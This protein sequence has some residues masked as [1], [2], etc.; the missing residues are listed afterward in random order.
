MSENKVELEYVVGVSKKKQHKLYIII[1][2]LLLLVVGLVY[3]FVLPKPTAT[4]EGVEQEEIITVAVLE[5][6]IDVSELSTFQA[7]YNGIAKV[8]NE[9]NPEEVDYYVCYEADVKVGIDFAEIDVEVDNI[10]KQVIIT[11]PEIEITSTNVDIGSL[12]YMFVNDKANT[13]TV[14]EQAYRECKADAEEESSKADKIYELAEQNARNI[15]RAL[16]SPF[17][18][19]VD[20]EYTLE[21]R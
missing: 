4:E 9:K 21:I 10:L 18:E 5:Q 8:M 7:V 1:V 15:V 17:V 6:I 14:S 16:T 3:Q 19:Q 20:S 2:V 13:N 11:L 12:E